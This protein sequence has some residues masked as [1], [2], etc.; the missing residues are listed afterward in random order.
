MGIQQVLGGSYSCSFLFTKV[1]SQQPSL[2]KRGAQ[3]HHDVSCLNHPRITKDMEVQAS[4]EL[5]Q[6]PDC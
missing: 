1:P 2:C 6:P 4:A 5:Q 3:F